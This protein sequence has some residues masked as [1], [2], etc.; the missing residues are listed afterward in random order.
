MRRPF[1]VW[2]L[3]IILLVLALGGGLYGGTIMLVDPTGNLLGVADVLPLLPVSNFILPGIFLFVVM[4]LFPLALVFGLITRPNWSWLDSYFGWSRFAWPWTLTI[5]LVV[6][7]CI[8]LAIEGLYM[9]FFPITYVTAVLGLFI[10]LFALLP[11]VR[12]FYMK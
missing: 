4:G 1:M 5:A 3:I 6:I 2:P 8:W 9:G 11:S 10:L 12:N 7:L